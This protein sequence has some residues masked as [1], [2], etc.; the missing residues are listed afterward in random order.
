M[1]GNKSTFVPFPG[2]SKTKQKIV[3]FPAPS[4]RVQISKLK[5][6]REQPLRLHAQVV[7]AFYRNKI[8]L[9][10]STCKART[11]TLSPSV[12][13]NLSVNKM[14]LLCLNRLKKSSEWIFR[15]CQVLELFTAPERTVFLRFVFKQ[16]MGKEKARK[17]TPR[18]KV[19][20]TRFL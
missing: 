12:Y 4:F 17:T 9:Y 10:Q 18:G 20:G 19:S 5:D 14:Y 15:F 13:K 3:S 1:A 2:S 16:M 7:P 8:I 11:P 6:M